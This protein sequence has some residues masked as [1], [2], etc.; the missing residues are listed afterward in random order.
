[1]W[2]RTVP[3]FMLPEYPG[4]N[5]V[6]SATSAA[7]FMFLPF[8]S[9]YMQSSAMY[10]FQG[11]LSP[12]PTESNNSCVRRTNSAWVVSRDPQELTPSNINPITKHAIIRFRTA[13]SW[14]FKNCDA[15]LNPFATS[16]PSAVAFPCAPPCPPWLRFLPY[17]FHANHHAALYR[18]PHS[19]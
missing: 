3:I 19:C 14:T 13:A 6:T 15:W 10:F 12:V 16:T 4:G 9:K 1:M 17:R 2:L 7:L 5:G 11:P 8:S 18:Q